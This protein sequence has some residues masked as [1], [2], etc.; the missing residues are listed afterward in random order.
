MRKI[1]LMLTLIV[2]STPAIAETVEV[3]KKDFIALIVGNYVNGF[4]E[5]DTTVMGFNDSV[6]VGIYYDTST[7][8]KSRAEQL[9][10]R[11]RLHIPGKLKT[12]SWEKPIK[13]LVTV[14]PEQRVE[15]GY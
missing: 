1:F 3:E 13:V 8:S 4:K 7:Q 14:Y 12:Y 15:R 10:K 6:S 11:F 2:M 9:A 5:F